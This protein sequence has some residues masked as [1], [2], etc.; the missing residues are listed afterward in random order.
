[1]RVTADVTPHHLTLQ[2][3][4][5][6]SY[7]SNFKMNPPLRS[8]KDQQ[9]LL[10]AIAEGTID[11]IATDHAPWSALYK[12]RPFE[13]CSSGILGFETAFPLVYEALV[14]SKII[15]LEHMI[16]LLT[17]RPAS[18]LNIAEKQ[19]APGKDANLA[20]LDLEQT[21]TYDVNQSF[22][23]SRNSPFHG[24]KLISKN[25]MTIYKGKVVFQDENRLAALCR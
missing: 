14:V 21:W 1:M 18:I 22:S 9:A 24:R 13:H 25:V 11:A 6:V 23:K 12:M 17:T 7:D 3:E 4:N 16:E 19:I 2:D 5:V 15:S 8:Q 10:A 20:I